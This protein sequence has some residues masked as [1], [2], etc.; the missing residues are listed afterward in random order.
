MVAS[1]KRLL[2]LCLIVCLFV[3]VAGLAQEDI[4]PA[5]TP[6]AREECGECHLDV[7]QAWQDS[8]HARTFHN[9]AFQSTWEQYGGDSQCLACHTTGFVART[10]EFTHPGVTCTACHGETP[11]NHPPEPIAVDPGMG[12]CIDC[13][14]TTFTEWQSS[15]HGEQQLACTTCHVP[16]PQQLRF[17]T[18]DALCLNCHTEARDDFAHITH[19]EQQCV[20]C[21]WHRSFDTEMHIMTGN[22]MPTGHDTR[23]ETRTCIDCH[24]SMSDEGIILSSTGGT[25]P[26]LQ[27]QVRI[28]E[29]EAQL[30]TARAQA[31]N[32][33]AV[34][35]AQGLVIGGFVTGLATVVVVWLRGRRSSEE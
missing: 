6:E 16:H 25:H 33:A 21:H 4:A 31:E 22:L 9:P 29:L 35:I 15:A 5:E 18:S 32:M 3:P 11:A 17:A 2:G 27:A 10:G 28:G 8:A 7:V 34:Q 24:A 1:A 20:D 30:T 13:H 19:L 12:V 23:V 26:L 14:A